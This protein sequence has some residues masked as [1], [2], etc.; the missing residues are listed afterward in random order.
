MAVRNAKSKKPCGD[1]PQPKATI[2]PATT[3][4]PEPIQSRGAQVKI[5]YSLPME[6]GLRLWKHVL[7]GTSTCIAMIEGYALLGMPGDPLDGLTQM[8]DRLSKV[9]THF[10]TQRNASHPPE[11]RT[12]PTNPTDGQPP[13]G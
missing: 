3:R 13:A 6:E 5:M 10:E 8:R 7:F 1:C 11:E 9:I 4:P 2:S 12:T